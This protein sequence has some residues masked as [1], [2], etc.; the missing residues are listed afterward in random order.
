MLKVSVGIFC[1]I[2][3]FPHNIVTDLNNVML[4]EM[5]ANIKVFI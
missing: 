3:S 2:L 1:I 5:D 4:H